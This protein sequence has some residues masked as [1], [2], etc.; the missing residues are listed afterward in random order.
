MGA[1]GGDWEIDLLDLNAALGELSAL[2]S[3][4]ARVFE[5]RFFGGL[6]FAEAASELAIAPKTAEADWY[7]A[8]AWL[9]QRLVQ[10]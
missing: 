8:R 5:L 6:S 10:H 3:R 7:M 4:K 2:D 9:Q 1:P